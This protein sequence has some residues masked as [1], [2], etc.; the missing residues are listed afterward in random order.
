M[1]K[2]IDKPDRWIFWN[3]L[4][5]KSCYSTLKNVARMLRKITSF[6]MP[7]ERQTG[8]SAKHALKPGSNLTPA[9]DSW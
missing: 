9:A 5:G 8:T 4:V 6:I 7:P 3:R 1:M 2:H